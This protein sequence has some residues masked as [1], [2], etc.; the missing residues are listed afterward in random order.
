MELERVG[1]AGAVLSFERSRSSMGQGSI[2]SANRAVF[3]IERRALFR[4]RA[5]Q[6]RPLQ[7]SN[8][9]EPTRHP[10][11]T[12]VAL[13]IQRQRPIRCSQASQAT[14]QTR[15]QPKPRATTTTTSS[16]SRIASAQ[17]PRPGRRPWRRPA[18]RPRRT[19]RG[20]RR[21]RAGR[22]RRSWTEA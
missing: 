12:T 1:A 19:A 7:P 11:Q 10:Q 17:S 18:S 20:A 21:P 6:F 22:R 9:S 13:T 14:A 16:T 3:S 2:F 8:R 4:F 15:P 5:L